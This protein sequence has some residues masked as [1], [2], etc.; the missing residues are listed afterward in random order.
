MEVVYSGEQP[1]KAPFDW[2]GKTFSQMLAWLFEE[3]QEDDSFRGLENAREIVERY[4]GKLS[5]SGTAGEV[6]IHLSLRF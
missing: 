4:S 2:K 1:Q 3:D 6:I 5:L